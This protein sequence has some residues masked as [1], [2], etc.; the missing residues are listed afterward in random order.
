M[1]QAFLESFKTNPTESIGP[2]TSEF[3]A[4]IERLKQAEQNF[5]YS[6]GAYVDVA[7]FEYTAA[8]MNISIMFKE[9][10]QEEQDKLNLLLHNF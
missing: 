1:L 6:F 2:R 9:M 5:N 7:T 4:S 3:E 8:L 10:K